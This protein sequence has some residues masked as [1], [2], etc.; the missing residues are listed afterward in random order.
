MSKQI[1]I[2]IRVIVLKEESMEELQKIVCDRRTLKQQERGALHLAG[3]YVI[4]M[5][6]KA[7]KSDL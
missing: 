1:K 5:P 4:V 3:H 6:T 7:I 2:D